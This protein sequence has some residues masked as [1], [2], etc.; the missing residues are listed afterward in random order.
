M[1][2]VTSTKAHAKILSVDPSAAL[3]MPG[4]VD[5]VGHKDVPAHNMYGPL[6]HDVPLFPDKEVHPLY[7]ILKI[8]L[9]IYVVQVFDN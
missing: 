2:Y 5:Y 9:L 8:L 3:A 1:S 6:V 7:F 4:V